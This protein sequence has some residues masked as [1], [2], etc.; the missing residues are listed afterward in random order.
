MFKIIL[1]FVLLL[2]LSAASFSQRHE[3]SFA[4]RIGLDLGD[5]TN[6][7]SVLSS[8]YDQGVAL[9]FKY[10]VW[11]KAN[12]YLM[13]GYDQSSARYSIHEGIFGNPIYPDPF[14]IV[15][16]NRHG[17]HFGLNKKFK[18]SDKFTFDLGINL[19][20]RTKHYENYT[21]TYNG[22]MQTPEPMFQ[23]YNF[24]IAP[25]YRDSGVEFS[26]NAHYSLSDK[27]SIMA[28][29]MHSRGLSTD[30]FSRATLIDASGNTTN[31]GEISYREINNFIYFNTGL[32]Y[33]L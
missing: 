1:F 20:T 28:G 9:Q 17:L 7:N 3:L 2:L 14:N 32:V 23:N 29:F 30:Y 6:T 16:V 8:S 26:A 31:T 22:G 18:L 15:N 11:E 33:K 27:F 25:Y 5:R 13:L 4:Y 19:T 12:L 21:A 24:T 10:R